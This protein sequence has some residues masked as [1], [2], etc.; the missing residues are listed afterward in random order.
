MN[1]NEARVPAGQTGGGQW[2]GRE[3]VIGQYKPT[4]EA[5]YPGKGDAAA[6]IVRKHWD[7]RAEQSVLDMRGMA[8]QKV[9]VGPNTY[10]EPLRALLIRKPEF[11]AELKTLK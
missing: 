1:E 3:S 11:A 4:V 5:K 8:G 9:Q 6:E 10:Q 7:A 2:T